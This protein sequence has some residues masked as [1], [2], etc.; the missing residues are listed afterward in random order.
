MPK[1]KSHVCLYLEGFNSLRN[2]NCRLAH[3]FVCLW[4]WMKVISVVKMV[5]FANNLLF[6]GITT[7]NHTH[8]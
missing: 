7:H 3:L 1:K 2:G 4:F 8:T 5:T 6:T